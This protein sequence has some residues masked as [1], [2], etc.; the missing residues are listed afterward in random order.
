VARI[1]G[2][3]LAEIRQKMPAAIYKASMEMYRALWREGQLDTR[4]R[5][6]LRLKSASLAGCIH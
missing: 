2:K 1:S 3:S 5:E 4:L 6:L